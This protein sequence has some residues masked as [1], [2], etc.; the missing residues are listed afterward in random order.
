MLL[1]RVKGSFATGERNMEK[2]LSKKRCLADNER[3]ADLINGLLLGG[4]QKVRS[5][6]L[7]ELD[8]QTP[9]WDVRISKDRSR[10]RQLNRDLV[11]K[12]AFGVNFAVIGLENQ[13]E[14]HYLM[15]VRAMAYDV[16]EYER[17]ARAARRVVRKE[18][19]LT[20]AEFL[21]GFRK[22][23]RLTPCITIVLYFGK[24]WDGS[25]SLHEL[26][27]FTDVPA[28]LK[29]Y[30]NNY[31][32]H[33]FEIAKMENTDVFT[34]DLKQIFDFIRCSGDER[35][36]KELIQNDPAYRSMDEEAY[37]M[38]VAYTNAKELIEAKQYHGKD[39]KVDMCEA[40]TKMLEDE[41]QEG[42]EEGRAEGREEGLEQGIVAF[43]LDNLEEGIPEERIT[44]KLTKRFFLTE[45]KAK[46]VIERCR[47]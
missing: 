21:S 19:G 7:Q 47:Q 39:G 31:S 34:T 15:P 42:R 29:E 35:K 43:V 1:R 33:V 5:C 38:A 6:D 46:E 22:G 11:K 2:D 14:V 45:E 4:K 10:Y 26:L 32:L 13:E 24:E 36:L 8:T 18:K 16:A 44:K 41:R 9:A 23:G 17:Q 20:R 30:I 3:Y 12:V 40:L 37:D 27:D 28:E 25:K